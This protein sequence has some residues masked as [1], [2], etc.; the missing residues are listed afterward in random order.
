MGLGDYDAITETCPARRTSATTLKH[1]IGDVLLFP[2]FRK[3]T[4]NG[5]GAQ[6]EIVG[7]AGFRLSGLD[8]HGSNETSSASS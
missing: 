1:R 5:T 7:W 4:G 8:L 6:Y 2:I 3:L